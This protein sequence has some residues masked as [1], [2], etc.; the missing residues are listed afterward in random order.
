MIK[1]HQL[2]AACQIHEEI[3]STSTTSHFNLFFWSLSL[4]IGLAYQEGKDIVFR[5]IIEYSSLRDFGAY[6]IIGQFSYEDFWKLIIL[7]CF[8]TWD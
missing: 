4:L 6:V 5:F 3:S 8:E 1:P 2:A 7:A